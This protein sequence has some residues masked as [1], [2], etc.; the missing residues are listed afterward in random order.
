MCPK[1]TLRQSSKNYDV[2]QNIQ[3]IVLLPKTANQ[4][5]KLKRL[6]V[7]QTII[8]MSKHIKLIMSISFHQ[9][10]NLI[11]LITSLERILKIWIQ[12]SF[13]AVTNLNGRSFFQPET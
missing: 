9:I 4:A 5:E 13:I 8:L 12:K 1:I 3:S 2:T 11:T 6:K 10:K 7:R